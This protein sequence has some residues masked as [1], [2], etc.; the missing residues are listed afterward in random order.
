MAHYMNGWGIT[1]IVIAAV[2]VI[3]LALGIPDAVRYL[4]I[5]RM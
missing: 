2:V 3:V 4:R 5:R 1:G